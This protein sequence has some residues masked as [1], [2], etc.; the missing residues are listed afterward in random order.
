MKILI[1]MALWGTFA[2][3]EVPCKDVNL[4]LQENWGK[5]AFLITGKE[6]RWSHY[7][8]QMPLYDQ[9]QTGICYSYAAIQ[10]V[11]YW[12]Q[13]MGIRI[14]KEI[15]LGSPLYAALL[16]RL[17]EKSS[18]Y[19]SKEL[20]GGDTADAIRAIKAIGMC[21]EDVIQE[22]LNNFAKKRGLDQREF[23]EIVELIFT[24]F[25]GDPEVIK[26]MPEK[27]IWK[28]YINNKFSY[29]DDRAINENGN[30]AKIFKQAAPYIK[31]GDLTQFMNELFMECQKPTSIYIGTKRIPEPSDIVVRKDNMAFIPDLLRGKL[32]QKNPQPIGIGYCSE[33][34][35]NKNF[36]GRTP[37]PKFDGQMVAKDEEKC[38]GHA[39]IIIGMSN[40]G[41]KCHYL[42]RNT[43]G[44]R[45][46]Y[47]WT[48]RFNAKKEAV[49][50]WVEE[51]AL[52]NNLGDLTY[53]RNKDFLCMAKT[54]LGEEVF[55][56]D[57]PSYPFNDKNWIYLFN[58]SEL[59]IVKYIDGMIS[60]LFG[61]DSSSLYLAEEIEEKKFKTV[62]KV[63]LSIPKK[64]LSLKL[65]CLP[66]GPNK[67][68]IVETLK[69]MNSSQ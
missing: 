16:T 32:L 9:G 27:D 65:A 33:V 59:L 39:S 6:T 23:L 42:V 10:L 30:L 63:S 1:F 4:T 12:R 25:P 15:M 13:T 21:R 61:K 50:I 36:L 24:E 37:D 29:Y 38:G 62:A 26:K 22:S 2:R 40:I 3:G 35:K 43:W 48:C 67:S 54:K 47:D 18:H 60:F 17:H 58:K 34:L 45:C 49:G 53:L 44:N 55:E 5:A 46:D 51:S 28:K 11:D 56:M 64:G 68:N 19:G 7:L 57:K 52:I 14:T 41:G 20:E 66:N 31:G 8:K 69:M